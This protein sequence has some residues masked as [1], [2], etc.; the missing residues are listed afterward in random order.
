MNQTSIQEKAAEEIPQ[1]SMQ[2]W[3]VWE[4]PSTSSFQKGI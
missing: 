4:I 3:M 1:K 2:L